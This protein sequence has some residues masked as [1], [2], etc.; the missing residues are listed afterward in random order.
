MIG[1]HYFGIVHMSGYVNSK[2]RYAKMMELGLYREKLTGKVII[3]DIAF[4]YDDIHYFFV[5]GGWGMI[6]ERK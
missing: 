2:E 1:V 4:A 3:L 5:K 6:N